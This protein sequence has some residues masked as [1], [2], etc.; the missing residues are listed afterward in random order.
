[1]LFRASIYKEIAAFILAKNKL[2][3]VDILQT[4]K[5]KSLN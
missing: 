5:P 4:I 3:G 1:M 2:I